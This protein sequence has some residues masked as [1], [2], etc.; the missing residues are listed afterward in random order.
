MVKI[1][2]KIMLNQRISSD[3]IFESPLSL[4]A[5]NFFEMVRELCGKADIPTPLILNSHIKHF[6]SFNQCKFKKSD[7]VESVRFDELV[8][9]NATE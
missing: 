2:V 4:T 6:K 9:E 5:D 1:W 3:F 7:F 8:L